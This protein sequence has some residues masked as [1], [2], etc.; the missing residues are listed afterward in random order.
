MSKKYP[1]DTSQVKSFSKCP[2]AFFI[3]YVNGF[4]LVKRESSYHFEFGT[5]FHKFLEDYH[6]HRKIHPSIKFAVSIAYLNDLWKDYVCDPSEEDKTAENGKQL[7]LQYLKHWEDIDG[8]FITVGVEE[9]VQLDGVHE[10][11]VVKLDTVVEQKGQYYGVEHKSTTVIRM[12]YFNP[13][14]TD[15][16][17]D[18]QCLAIRQKYGSCSGIIIDVAGVKLYKR[19]RKDGSGPGLICDFE[20]RPLCRTN[21]QMDDAILQMNSWLRR[22]K[23][24]SLQK[25]FEKNK[26]G[27]SCYFP[28]ECKHTE[29]CQMSKGSELDPQFIVD[30]YEKVNPFAYLEE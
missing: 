30:T 29:L 12:G 13:F 5:R 11:Y 23:A 18:A 22:M 2:F 7:C 14:K 16:Q 10:P 8:K 24:A 19:K 25:F 4:D 15:L 26:G 20:R 21:L 17:I 27:F 6:K 1:Y 9:Q 3:K 28:K